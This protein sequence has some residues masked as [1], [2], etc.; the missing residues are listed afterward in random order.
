MGD[1]TVNGERLTALFLELLQINSP[2]RQEGKIAGRM[3]ELLRELGAEIAIDKAGEQLGG[4][5]G[6]I[7]ARIPGTIDAPPL[8]FCSHLDTV[9]PTE[10]LD[11]RITE[12]IISSDGTTILGADDKAGLAAIIEMLRMLCDTGTPH[13]PLEIA[14]T[15]AEEVGLMG[16]TVLDYSMLTARTGF[17]PDGSGAVGLIITR[18]PAQKNVK[19]FIR[20]RAAHAGMA[21]EDGINA[22]TVA[23]RAIARVPQGRIDEE[24]TANI[25]IIRGGKATNI[26]PDL[27]EIEGEARSRDPQKLADQVER[28]QLCFIEEAE[29]AGASAEVIIT[30]VYPSFNLDEGNLAVSL[31]TVAAVETGITPIVAATGGGSDANFLN[32]HGIHTVI[33]SAGYQHPHGTNESMPED[34]LVLLAQW[35]FN[36]A[37]AGG[38]GKF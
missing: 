23:S 26:V 28:M 12:G 8:L 1:I 6:N 27:V 13:P 35:L 24:T 9:E 38:G 36:I 37:R 34:Q 31:A 19:V 7:I 2:S 15:I 10:Q 11:I 21:P 20:G 25:G 17:V 4:E 30:D 22:I 18:A 33:L 5:T 14:F 16:S 32:G 3:I 29:K